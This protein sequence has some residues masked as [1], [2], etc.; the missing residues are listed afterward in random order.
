MHK[1]ENTIL[2]WV[3]S[4]AGFLLALL[5]SPIGSP[6]LYRHRNYFNENQGVN[7]NGE[8]ISRGSREISFLKVIANSPRGISGQ[9]ED[10]EINIPTANNT[11][12]KKYN[13]QVSEATKSVNHTGSVVVIANNHFTSI[14]KMNEAN[15]SGS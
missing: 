5:Y 7:F 2:I 1:S 3:L 4:W 15:I 9:N 12:G 8:G 14:N 10:A 11:S 13:Y 6:D